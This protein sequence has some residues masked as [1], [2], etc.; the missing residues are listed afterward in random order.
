MLTDGEPRWRPTD[1]LSSNLRLR[2]NPAEGNDLYLVWNGQVLT[3]RT[4]YDPVPRSESRTFV[5]KYARTLTLD[6]R[7]IGAR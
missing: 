2:Y 3:D 4:L 6:W 5:L 1:R 7:G